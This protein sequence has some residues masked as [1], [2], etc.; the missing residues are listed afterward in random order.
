MVDA[1][2]EKVG[3][4]SIHFRRPAV[5]PGDPLR[6]GQPCVWRRER[7]PSALVRLCEGARAELVPI[8]VQQLHALLHL[9]APG[10]DAVGGLGVSTLLDQGGVGDLRTGVRD[11]GRADRPR[12]RRRTMGRRRGVRECLAGADDAS[13]RSLLGPGGQPLDVSSSSSRCRC[14]CRIATASRRSRSPSRWKLQAMFFGPFLLGRL[15]PRPA[16]WPWLA[17]VPA[18]SISCWRCPVLGA[19]RPLANVLIDLPRPGGRLSCAQRST[20]RTSGSSGRSMRPW[21]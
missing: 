5:R 4:A 6:A 9:C 18:V 13:Q 15:F 20:R 19:G 7:L 11:P 16:L 14:S 8:P 10:P 1:A 21:A 2:H 3:Q 17:S 12:H